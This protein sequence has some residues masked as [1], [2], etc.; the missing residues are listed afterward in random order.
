[1]APSSRREERAAMVFIV[2]VIGVR[3][4]EYVVGF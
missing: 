4:F 3:L 1:M 2:A